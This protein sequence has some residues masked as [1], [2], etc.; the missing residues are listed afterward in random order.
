MSAEGN[1]PS[2]GLPDL[3]QADGRAGIVDGDYPG[4]PLAVSAL[5]LLDG[6]AG[7]DHPGH[8]SHGTSMIPR[9]GLCATAGA[10]AQH[11]AGGLGRP[12]AFKQMYV[13][14]FRRGDL[15]RETGL[16]PATL[17]L[18]RLRLVFRCPDPFLNLTMH[19]LQIE[20][21]GR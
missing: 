18:G 20:A 16:E 1:A 4:D 5:G 9:V 13:Y 7:Q 6:H 15:E 19:L 10:D 3:A 21:D 8:C 17:C 14:R 11:E 2:G 12:T